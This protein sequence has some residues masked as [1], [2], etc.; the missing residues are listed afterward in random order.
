MKTYIYIR[1]GSDKRGYNVNI[2]VY[3]V[4]NNVPELIGD[5]DWHTA[6]WPGERGAAVRMITEVDG[7]KSDGYTFESKNIQIFQI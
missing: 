2:R 6:S 3:R 4:K 5:S 1:D 7:H